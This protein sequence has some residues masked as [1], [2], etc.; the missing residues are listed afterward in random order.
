MTATSVAVTW[1]DPTDAAGRRDRSASRRVRRSGVRG[2]GR[3]GE[4]RGT[5]APRG[6][7]TARL[8]FLVCPAGHEHHLEELSARV[9]GPGIPD[10][11]AI[12]DLRARRDIRQLTPLRANRLRA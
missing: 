7:T 12:A 1:R 5:A 3:Y 10:Q 2:T 4:V 9:G 6:T 11:H 8:L